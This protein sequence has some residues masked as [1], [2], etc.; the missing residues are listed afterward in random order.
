MTY[1]KNEIVPSR[2]LLPFILPE[3][4][5][6]DARAKSLKRLCPSIKKL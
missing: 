6:D 3:N 4:L 1:K 2:M 5:K